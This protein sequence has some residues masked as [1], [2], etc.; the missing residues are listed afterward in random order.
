MN[1]HR[2][3]GMAGSRG[4][5]S[6]EKLS[7]GFRINRGGDDAAGLSISEK[8]RG[9]IRGLNQA[10]RNGQDAISLIQTAADEGVTLSFNRNGES[11]SSRFTFEKDSVENSSQSLNFFSL[12]EEIG[13]LIESEINLTFGE[14]Q[15]S[16]LDL[17]GGGFLGAGFTIEE[18]KD[19]E[20]SFQIGANSSQNTS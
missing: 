6:M 8:M 12:N 11:F 14:F 20:V 2:Q 7:S 13:D 1:T 10:S 18:E 5:K 15:T 17:T 19:L 9:Q 3:L 16:R 4:A